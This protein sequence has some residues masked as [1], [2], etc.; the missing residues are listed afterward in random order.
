MNK[1]FRGA[2]V[3]GLATPWEDFVMEPTSATAITEC[4]GAIKR[5]IR[6]WSSRAAFSRSNAR[7]TKSPRQLAAACPSARDGPAD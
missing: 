1:T 5:Y 3:A 6:V 2:S 7:Q 4:W